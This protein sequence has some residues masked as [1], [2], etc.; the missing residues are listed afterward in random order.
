MNCKL[1]ILQNNGLIKYKES[2]IKF[3]IVEK[4]SD[5]EILMSI[6]LPMTFVSYHQTKEFDK[7]FKNKMNCMGYISDTGNKYKHIRHDEPFVKQEDINKFIEELPDLEAYY[8]NGLPDFLEVYLNFCPDF[9][10]ERNT[11]YTCDYFAFKSYYISRYCHKITRLDIKE[12]RENEERCRNH[13]N[14]EFMKRVLEG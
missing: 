2:S 4:K 12:K 10:A 9:K 11:I 1:E 13:K 7:E 3:D 8:I 6:N 14:I 5:E